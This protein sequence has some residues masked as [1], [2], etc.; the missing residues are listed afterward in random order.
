MRNFDLALRTPGQVLLLERGH[1][2]ALL[3]RDMIERP[4]RPSSRGLIARTMTAV[5]RLMKPTA[6]E[7]DGDESSPP[8][9][10]L[11]QISWAGTVEYAEGYAIVD[12]IAVID[13]E[14]VLT[15][16]GYIDWWNWCYC[17]GYAQIGAALD[18]ARDDERIGGIFLRVDSPGGYIDGCFDLA[19]AIRAGNKAGGGKPI[20]TFA[21]MACSAAYALASATDR[22]VAT[23]EAEV[24]SIGVL[25]MHY[26]VSGFYAEHGIKIEAIQ[27]GARKTDG[28]DWKP[29]SDDARAHLQGVVDQIARRFSATVTAGRGISAEDIAALQARWFLAQHDDPAQSGLALKLVDEIAAERAA[30][31]ALKQSLTSSTGGAKAG[32]GS[33]TASDASRTATTETDMSLT[34][35]IAALRDKAAKG[36]AAALAELKALGISPKADAAPA[37]DDDDE[38]ED[39]PDKKDGE[40]DD[41]EED[42]DKEPEAKATGTKAGF[43]VM[44]HKEAKGRTDLA[45]KLAKK[46]S[47]G[48]MTYGEAV[49][50][51]AAAPKGSRLGNVMSGRDRN[52]GTDSGG[53]GR[54][55]ANAGLAAAVDR[56]NEKK[57]ARR[58]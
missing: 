27:S 33:Q 18:A 2:Q 49:D 14:G 36:D 46:V 8:R 4:T 55:Q 21:R 42:D 50:M 3:D 24:G 54:S 44:G 12:G 35:Q 17:P 22:I 38:D 43:A 45:T 31:M 23:A 6:M 20:W 25:V 13:I 52:P 47:G 53:D 37:D 10:A 40:G 48:K 34:E 5:G 1:A 29:L 41:D 15:P 51:L 28:A 32:S 57:A 30:F 19:D 7:D 39:E 26:D 16:D 9:M 58:A 11:P 56:M